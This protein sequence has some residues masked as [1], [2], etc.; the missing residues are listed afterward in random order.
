MKIKF[1]IK[2]R[3]EI[4]SGKY[5]VITADGRNARTVNGGRNME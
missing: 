2:Y 3:P 4:E 5:K 1:D